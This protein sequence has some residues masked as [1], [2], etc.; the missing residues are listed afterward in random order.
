M[1]WAGTPFP[2]AGQLDPALPAQVQL[3]LVCRTEAVNWKAAAGTGTR[4]AAVAKEVNGRI[5]GYRIYEEK[6]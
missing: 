6:A 5:V 3:M 2:L 1:L 4:V